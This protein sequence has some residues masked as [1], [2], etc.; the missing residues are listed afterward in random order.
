MEKVWG[1]DSLRRLEEFK[2]ELGSVAPR[3]GDELTGI[4]GGG[5]GG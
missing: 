3:G 4:G 1:L 2:G 5:S